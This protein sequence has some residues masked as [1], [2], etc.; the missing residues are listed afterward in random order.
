[1]LPK[2]GILAGGGTLP[3]RL[4]EHCRDS[5]RECFVIAFES[6]CDAGTVAGVAHAWCRLGAA[7]DILSAL[8]TTGVREIVLA[9]RIRRPSLRD[10]R[11]DMQGWKILARL[12]PSFFG[13]DDKLLRAVADVLEREGFHIVGVHDVIQD[14][15]APRG[16]LGRVPPG[17]GALRDIAH[18]I[19]AARELG[20]RDLGQGVIVRDGRVV[21]EEDAAGTDALIRRAAGKG[22][23]LVK[24][25]K[26][27][28][29]TRMDLPAIGP[30][31]VRLAAEAGLVGIAVEAGHALILDRAETVRAADAAGLFLV[32]ADGG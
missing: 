20:A 23:V 16:V 10:V 8:R 29:D 21:A 30:D 7:G 26:P 9:G 11:P 1:M 24:M 12:T 2:L 14:L 5:G 27:Q 15:L 32:G 6:H 25:R 13:G 17:A 22:G 3:K 28:Q 4:I 19:A 31:T 18:G